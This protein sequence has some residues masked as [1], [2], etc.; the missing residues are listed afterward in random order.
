[1]REES[2]MKA[3]AHASRMTNRNR[4]HQR[5]SLLLTIGLICVLSVAAALA[6][7]LCFSPVATPS[8]P[9]NWSQPPL[10]DGSIINGDPRCFNNLPNLGCSGPDLGWATAFGYVFNNPDGPMTPDVIVEGNTDGNY[11][12][13]SVQANNSSTQ[14]LSSP[15]DANNAVVVAFDPDNSGTKM[16]WF[17]IYVTNGS[18]IGN[19]SM[20]QQVDYYWN[21]GSLSS[22]LTDPA[23]FAPNP[24]WLYGAGGTATTTSWNTHCFPANSTAGASPCLQSDL[25]GPL[26]SME[27]ALP[28]HGPTGDPSTGLILPTTGLFGMYI[29]VL[30]VVGSPP[31]PTSTG[32]EQWAQAPWPAGG[33]IT[34]C[35][36]PSCYLDTSIPNPPSLSSPPSSSVWGSGTIQNPP[37]PSCNGLSIGSQNLD[38]KITN[39]TYP[40][41]SNAIDAMN[42]NTFHA[43]VHNT[44]PQADNVA[45]TFF[46]ANFGLP[47]I[48]WQP[49]A[50]SPP[51]PTGS[52]IP[53]GGTT[54][55]S[56][57]FT[58]NATQLA[59]YIANPHQCILATLSSSPPSTTPPTGAF[60]VNNSAVQNADFFDLSRVERPVE[61][62]SRGYAVN[63]EHNTTQEFD[64]FV[65]TKRRVLKSCS[66]GNIPTTPTGRDT[67]DTVTTQ[68]SDCSQLVETAEACRHTGTYLSN[69]NKQKIE[70]C[71][72]VGSFTFV[73]KHQGTGQ[74]LTYALT[75]PGLSKPDNN[76]VYHL[77]LANDSVVR[78]NNV[79]E[80]GKGDCDGLPFGA[81]ALPVFGG[82]FVVGLIVYRPR[83]KE[84]KSE[85]Q[86]QEQEEV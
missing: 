78:L 61:V 9:P 55:T 57:S 14:T 73:A 67:K 85:E 22:P 23:H 5:F 86:K 44:G 72:P 56:N 60:F 10:I 12:Y 28:L 2:N 37:S 70:L 20:A 69:N 84:E 80:A 42:P 8:G 52:T 34:N 59:N 66:G 82:I 62:S 16:Q 50:F 3:N 58:P 24:G 29:D 18:E 30:R 38:I 64:L 15:T 45:V 74:N 71:Q 31:T 54:L 48:E 43:N 36:T 46:I 17:V 75:G 4:R 65:T 26:W 76:G 32:W 83:K 77:S 53:S 39:S 63:P 49:V 40:G 19:K 33:A 51:L 7:Q 79:I 1:M 47:S 81:T 25:E 27:M 13:L 6:Q 68:G 41:G 11:L 35:S 21:Q